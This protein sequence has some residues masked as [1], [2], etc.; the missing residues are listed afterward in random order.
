MAL[1]AGAFGAGDF[2]PRAVRMPGR[3]D[4]VKEAGGV[5]VR[6]P[7][8]RHGGAGRGPQH[9]ENEE[10]AHREDETRGGGGMSAERVV[11][12]LVAVSLVGLLVLAVKYPDRF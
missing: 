2:A 11:G 5:L 4:S 6:H 3:S 10:S 12:I 8:A 1:P 7:A 9:G